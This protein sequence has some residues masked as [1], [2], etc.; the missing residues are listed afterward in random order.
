MKSIFHYD[1]EEQTIN[2]RWYPLLVIELKRDL[3]FLQHH[4]PYKKVCT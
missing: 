4:L 2:R 1:K 3:S